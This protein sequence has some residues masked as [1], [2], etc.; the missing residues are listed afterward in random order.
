MVYAS[1]MRTLLL[2]ALL[3]ATSG[4]IIVTD[5]G[6]PRSEPDPAPPPQQTTVV[7]AQG[8]ESESFMV[9]YK[10]RVN[11]VYEGIKKACGRLNIKLT[12]AHTP[13]DDNWTIK[14]FH[15]AGWFDL[16]IYLNRHDH[17]TQTNVTIRSGRLNQFQ[18]REWTR[19]VHGELGRQLGE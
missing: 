19:K 11:E 9:K 2:L 7:V 17:K 15:T 3:A 12:D 5:D 6:G 1:G 14:G 4:C 8:P 16:E 13:G 10:P 18:C